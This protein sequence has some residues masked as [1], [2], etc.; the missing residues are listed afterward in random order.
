MVCEVLFLKRM[1]VGVLEFK[2]F[3]FD[4][5]SHGIA[6]ADSN[7]DPLAC[8]LSMLARLVPGIKKFSSHLSAL[9]KH[10]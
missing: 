3:S 9:Q 1:N 7:H 4:S 2:D 8:V 5:S 10:L 6:F